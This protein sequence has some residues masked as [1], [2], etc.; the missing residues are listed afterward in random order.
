MM[1]C[2]KFAHQVGDYL[3]GRLP[4]GE[5]VA[6]WIHRLICTPCR[7]YYAQI[8]QVIA[9]TEEVGEHERAT[10]PSPELKEEMVE[11]FRARTGQ[12]E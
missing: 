11:Q 1:R 10:A 5:R 4:F 12:G 8:R 2:D 3:E 6:M 7:R 9:L